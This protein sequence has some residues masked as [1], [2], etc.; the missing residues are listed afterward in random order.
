MTF[1]SLPTH[2]LSS[3]I[4]RLFCFLL[5]FCSLFLTPVVQASSG[6]EPPLDTIRLL[7]KWR[8][9]FQF[10]GYY[11]AIEKGYFREAGLNV[12]LMPGVP[13]Q[14]PADILLAGQVEYAVMSPA[15]LL[16]RQQ[17]KPL[18]VLAAIFQHSAD[19]IMTRKKAGLA[20]PQDLQGKR[21]ML[22]PES[23]PENRA[24]L[25]NEGVPLDS[26]VILHH[27][28]SIDD[29]LHNKVDG[30]TAY[31]TNEPYL[32]KTRGVEPALIRPVSYGIDFYGDCL[33]T[34]ER[35]IR[36]HPERAEAFRQAVQKGWHYAMEHPEE[37]AKLI[38]ARYSQEK[39]LEHL[40]FE[41]A[42]MRELIRPDLVEI[43]YMNPERWRHIADSYVQLGMLSP[44]YS[45]K[46]FL[47]S[48]VQ[49]ELDA[50]KYRL[51]H[52]ALYFLGG[53]LILGIGAGIVLLVFNNRLAVQVRKRTA[54]LTASEQSFRAFFEMASVG[55]AQADAYSG[56][57]RKVNRKYCEI[58]GYTEE[59]MVSFTF[60]D[61]TYPDDLDIDR[62]QR[63]ELI[64][65][66]IL[67]FT[68]EKRY[69]RK[70]GSVVW[71][72]LTVSPLWGA[73]QKPD[74]CLAVIQDITKRKMAEEKLVFA[75]KVFE[76]SIEGIVVTDVNGTIVQTNPAFTAITGYSSGEA[77][78][79]NPKILKSNK[80]PDTFYQAMWAQL[81]Q[82]GQW[83]GEIWNRRKNGEIYP[84]WLTINAVHDD[85][86]RISNYVSIFHDITELKRQQEALE[87]QAQHDA[88][89]GMPNRVL[90]NDRLQMALT[91]IKR[92]DK[93]VALLFLDLDNFKHVN[94]GFGHTAGDNLLIELSQRLQGQLRVGDT[95]ARQGGDE[96][97]ILLAEV[98]NV[99]DASLIAMRL[100]ESLQQPFY[101]Q[102]I[103]YYVTASIG[104]TIA[105]NDGTHA[106]VLI[107]NADMAMY[108]AKKLG[109]NNF[110]YFTPELDGEAHRRISLE[111][112]LRKGIELE[113]FELYYQPLVSSAS[114]AVIGAEALIRWHHAGELISPS[115]FIP[116]A[117]E[118]G[119]ILPLGE[120]V[121]KAA[122]RQAKIWQDA[123]SG[124]D[125]S[126]NISSRQFAGQELAELLREV[127]ASTGL[128]AGRLY[129]EITESLLMEDIV[130]AR[131][132]LCDL[133]EQGGKFYLDDFG[134]GYSSLS[135]LKRLP[136]DGLK[137]D[138]SFIRDIGTDTDSRA[139]AAAIVSLAETLNLAIVAEGVETEEQLAI[140]RSMSDKLIIQG[141]LASPPVPA[142]RFETFLQQG[143]CLLPG[144]AQPSE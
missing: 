31:L 74:C 51:V 8:H 127:L 33:V 7:L 6:N 137:I 42:A 50:G 66:K 101:H 102:D 82:E 4:L 136:L 144:V 124:L 140:L 48:Q 113:E 49:E 117:E 134:T 88:L 39:S 79:Q 46:G 143:Y 27:S 73:G 3:K 17:G 57:F 110:Q 19:I 132:I 52:R 34:S 122:A 86:Q 40:L 83:A 108:R 97:L 56:R 126:V 25:V 80:H 53:V 77:I 18:V 133:R 2:G 141:Y 11:A 111:S 69:T 47:Y 98:E 107:K 59:E 94:D 103:E 64:E 1:D 93:K 85:Q 38:L 139:I 81:G 35:E 120:W 87:H 106:D 123:G 135:Y 24:M 130:K 84:E 114:G 15:V 45:L 60:R 105:P 22:A 112:L 32:L 104:V 109:R 67:E 119:L 20:T 36:E 29:L 89:T 138:R 5:A 68:V 121:L 14:H 43:G 10:A 95:L 129:F 142:D 16:E 91:R 21:I 30:Q 41:A 125:I 75:D 9:Q 78:G 58:I 23:D 63:R 72:I 13:D 54:A 37:I 12:T 55:V 65:G 90:L 28:W 96:F 44:N 62:Q 99:D 61:I 100:L 70:N 71:V 128:Q 116:L 118:S 131:K 92:Q 115:E 76:H 26:M